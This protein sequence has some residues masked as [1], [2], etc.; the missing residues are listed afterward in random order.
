MKLVG[1]NS[2]SH[3]VETLMGE[4]YGIDGLTLTALN[5]LD[6]CNSF[7]GVFTRVWKKNRP[8][9][10]PDYE[11]KMLETLKKIEDI[12]RDHH[13]HFSPNIISKG[14]S[15]TAL[16]KSDRDLLSSEKANVLYAVMEL[17]GIV[18]FE[19][20]GQANNATFVGKMP[21][22]ITKLNLDVRDASRDE[23]VRN[24]VMYRVIHDSVK[25][26]TVEGSDISIYDF[27]ARHIISLLQKIA[28]APEI[29]LKIVEGSSLGGMRHQTLCEEYTKRVGRTAISTVVPE[30]VE[31]YE[32]SSENVASIANEEGK[33]VNQAVE[34]SKSG[35]SV[36]EE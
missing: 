24:D 32:L 3:A 19:P 9:L 22:D 2:G 21:E 4:M 10:G 27:E 29:V 35:N 26:R 25:H 13:G 1:K 20:L 30:L 14:G 7:R 28:E 34:T 12:L 6:D 15:N 16:I 8:T 5:G 11:K 31:D 23:V 36:G 33:T 18:V 17:N